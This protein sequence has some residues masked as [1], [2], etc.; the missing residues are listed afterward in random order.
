MVDNVYYLKNISRLEGDRVNRLYLEEGTY[1]P[2]H[3]SYQQH[4]RKEETIK[5]QDITKVI[6]VD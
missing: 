1:S 2:C 5:S 6:V 3:S 4:R